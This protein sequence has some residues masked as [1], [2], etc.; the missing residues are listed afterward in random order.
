[1]REKDDESVNV[2]DCEGS[3]EIELEYESDSVPV[4]VPE[5][6]PE[7]DTL[8]EGDRL[9]VTAFDGDCVPIESL[10]EFVKVNEAE[11]E[12]E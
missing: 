12:V 11:T 7:S 9:D 1:M 2:S 6:C 10:C 3:C 8:T 4:F 5:S